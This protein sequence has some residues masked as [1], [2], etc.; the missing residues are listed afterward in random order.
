MTCGGDGFGPKIIWRRKLRNHGPCCIHKSPVLSLRYTILLRGV[1]SGILMCNPLITKKPFHGVVLEL[2]TVVTSNHQYLLFEL[3]LS[4]V[5]E[6]ND[7]LLSP[8]LLIE[9]INPCVS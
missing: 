2:G 9:E 1:R 4:H 8:T 5:D 7:S 6:V 3:T